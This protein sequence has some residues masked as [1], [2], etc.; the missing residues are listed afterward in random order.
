[1]SEDRRGRAKLTSE[2]IVDEGADVLCESTC[3]HVG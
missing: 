1:M 3:N 2:L